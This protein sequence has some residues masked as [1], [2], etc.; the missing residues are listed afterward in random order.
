MSGKKGKNGSLSD[1]DTALWQKVTESVKPYRR[2]SAV[3]AKK[4]E[5]LSD[6]KTLP[7]KAPLKKA[8]IT[9]RP[10]LPS[11]KPAS[12]TATAKEPRGFDTATATKLKKGQLG[13]EGTI[14]LHDMT[15]DQAFPV[16]RRFILSHYKRGSRTLLVITGKGR[17]SEG[18]GVL[19]RMLPLWLGDRDLAPCILALT[20]AV[21]KDGGSGAFYVRLRK[22]RD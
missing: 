13:I 7:L 5:K 10:A 12:P 9:P 4:A 16:L 19:K 20:P 22:K 17:V 11:Y 18:G 15:Q 8:K 2:K 21:A 14:D 6:E 1:E 3:L